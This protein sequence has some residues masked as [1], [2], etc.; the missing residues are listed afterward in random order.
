MIST[1]SCSILIG[2]CINGVPPFIFMRI[3]SNKDTNVMI[4]AYSIMTALIKNPDNITIFQNPTIQHILFR[5]KHIM[6]QIIMIYIVNPSTCAKPKSHMGIISHRMC[7]SHIFQDIIY[8]TFAV[9]T[10]SSC[11][12]P[13]SKTICSIVICLCIILYIW[14]SNISAV[15]RVLF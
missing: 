4:V 13:S 6:L 5:A 9:H 2:F 10:Y 1:N 7:C 8:E 15:C 11:I 12:Q 14:S 3:A